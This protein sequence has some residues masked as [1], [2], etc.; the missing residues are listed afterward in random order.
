MVRDSTSEGENRK[1]TESGSDDRFAVDARQ[2]FA[3][4]AWAPLP[5][6]KYQKELPELALTLA[7]EPVLETHEDFEIRQEQEDFDTD[8]IGT[9]ALTGDELAQATKEML[10]V[11]GY[12]NPEIR[13]HIKRAYSEVVREWAKQ[14]GEVVLNLVG[15]AA[16]GIRNVLGL[17]DIKSIVMEPA[18]NAGHA[19][20]PSEA[21]NQQEVSEFQS[22]AL[23]LASYDQSE[24][25]AQVHREFAEETFAET[26]RRLHPDY[27]KEIKDNS[28]SVRAK[29]FQDQFNALT[30]KFRGPELLSDVKKVGHH[31]FSEAVMNSDQKLDEAF[32][33]AMAAGY[34]NFKK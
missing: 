9:K 18:N 17:G 30:N 34:T 32:I 14:A 4:E 20:V 27:P 33:A 5:F 19:S 31:E 6:I 25:I 23:Q 16:K 2:T 12:K 29:W 11:V 28:K 21:E 1:R 26:I 22:S 24:N 10:D 7:Q 13:T 8:A 3:L 15:V